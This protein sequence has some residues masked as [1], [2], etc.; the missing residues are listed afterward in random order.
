MSL[1]D[2]LLA[3]IHNYNSDSYYTYGNIPAKKLQNACQ[4]FPVDPNDTPLALVDTTVM[5]SAKTGLVI[6]LK[7]IYFR[8]DWATKTTKN[9][10]SWEDLSM[11][12]SPIGNGALYCITLING[13]ELN[14]SGS[15]MKKEVLTNLLNQIISLYKENR[16]NTLPTPATK[17][18]PTDSTN[19]QNVLQIESPAKKT[20][21]YQE[22][23]PEILALCITADGAV[24][25]DEIEMACALLDSDEFIDNKSEATS[26][27]SQ[28]TEKL[29]AERTKS[30]ALFKLKA[31]TII[32]KIPQIADTHQKERI[33]I[34]LDAMAE[35]ANNS[36]GD[37]FIEVISKIRGKL[38]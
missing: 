22:I 2:Q 36:S 12:R 38:I 17:N 5:G 15:S 9:F 13:C 19:N 11:N 24:D 34:I 23:V 3:I 28:L 33:T 18:S 29:S 32:S 10:S 7:G 14:M 20:S 25:E 21:L 16:S 1:E 6:G 4:N 8:N 30:K 35:T 31:A 27:L 37:D 26:I